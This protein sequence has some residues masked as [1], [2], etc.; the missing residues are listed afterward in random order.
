LILVASTIAAVAGES[1]A[2][3]ASGTTTTSG[4]STSTSILGVRPKSWFFFSRITVACGVLLRGSV[5]A[6]ILI[7]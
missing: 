5:L 7:G 3:T 4:Y 1:A 6:E 2:A